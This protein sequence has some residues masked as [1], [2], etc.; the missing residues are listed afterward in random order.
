MVIKCHQT[1]YI[2]LQ[3]PVMHT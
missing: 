3:L 1:K 2:G